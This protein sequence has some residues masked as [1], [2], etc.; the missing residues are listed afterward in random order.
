MKHPPTLHNM[1]RNY[2][3]LNTFVDTNEFSQPVQQMYFMPKSIPLYPPLNC[4]SVNGSSV[5]ESIFCTK[6]LTFFSLITYFHLDTQCILRGRQSLCLVCYGSYA[7]I[8]PGIEG[9]DLWRS[10]LEARMCWWYSSCI[11]AL[12]AE[13]RK[14]MEKRKVVGL[15][16]MGLIG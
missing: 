3:S 13:K 16:F 6:P 7:C 15:W 4:Q 8:C 10:Y 12:W 9:I 2:V 5:N 14:G 11:G 1:P